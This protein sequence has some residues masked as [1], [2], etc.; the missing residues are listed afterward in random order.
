[1]RKLFLVTVDCDLRADDP[2]ARA[3]G[4]HA[5]LETLGEAGLSGRVTWFLN[6]NDFGFTQHHE[7]FLAEAAGRG[8]TIG[9]HDHFEPF[10][11]QA[12]DIPVGYESRSVL[13]Y[14]RASR[15]RVAGWLEREGHPAQVRAHRNGYLA[16]APEIYEALAALGYTVLSDI[17]PRH[18][19]GDRTGAWLD[20]SEI[21]VGIGP[22]RHDAHNF[23]DYASRA[24]RFLQAPIAAMFLGTFRY[25]LL[26]RWLEASVQQEAEPAVFTW[27]LHPY[28]V[29]NDARDAVSPGLVAVLRDHLR[30]ISADYDLE[31]ASLTQLEEIAG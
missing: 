8:D 2:R 11:A 4:L 12:G 19:S 5:V 18:R 3:D 31:F 22:Y 20:N 21:P 1:M 9:I 30:H 7:D 28:E 13:A 15:D 25:E 27:C 23:T 17:W 24:G 6:E 26:D 29:L 10:T 14:C 16:Q